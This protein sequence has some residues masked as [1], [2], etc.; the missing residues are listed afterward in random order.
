MTPWRR[1]CSACLAVALAAGTV[2]VSEV[3]AIMA[4]LSADDIRRAID[5]GARAIA[6]EDF[7]EEWRVQLPRGEEILV[8]TPYARIAYAARRAA[9]KEEPLADKQLQEQVERGQGKLQLQVTMYGREVDF[10]RWYQA[11]LRLGT[12]EVKA[13]FTQNERTALKMEDGRFAARNIY[14]FPLEGIPAQ[15]VVTL[16]VQHSIERKEILR[17]SLDLGKM[18]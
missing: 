7:G 3:P 16:V 10:A 13:T 8:T 5:E 17:A 2:V 15:G 1:L 4:S 14:V 18:R 12:R 6:K 9:F 11:V